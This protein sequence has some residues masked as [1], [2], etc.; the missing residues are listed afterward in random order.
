MRLKIPSG[1]RDGYEFLVKLDP[2]IFSDKDDDGILDAN[3]VRYVDSDLIVWIV[4][5]SGAEEE[6]DK[7]QGRDLAP[8]RLR[9]K[10][11][12]LYPSGDKFRTFFTLWSYDIDDWFQVDGINVDVETFEELWEEQVDGVE[13]IDVLLY[14]SGFSLF[15]IK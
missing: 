11:V 10:E 15:V 6:L 7:L 12:E 4:R 9:L 1:F 3:E 14:S 5:N 13:D 8:H 2:H